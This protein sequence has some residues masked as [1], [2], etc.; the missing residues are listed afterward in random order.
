[1]NVVLYGATGKAG[2]RLLKELLSRG[3]S[4]TAIVR[5]PAKLTPQDRLI[6]RK[7]DLSDVTRIAEDVRGTEAVISAYGPGLN[8]P[9]ELA[10]AIGR[11]IAGLKLAGVPRLLMVGG[12][13]S[14]EVAPGVQLIDSGYLPPE[15]MPISLAH[16]DA[17]EVLRSSDLDWTC[18]SPAAYF[19]PGERTGVFRVGKD[20]LV[21]NEK[22]DSRISME[23]YAIA[24]VD[25]LEN[26]AH[27]RQRFSVGY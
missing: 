19:E 22:G 21:A 23:D 13:G 20:N 3:H 2:V 18:L 5:E 4:V 27:S 8:A 26:Q 6:I 7:G 10:G 9:S 24:M 17:L 16:R 25:E 14:L 1:M 11:L 12:A 15:W